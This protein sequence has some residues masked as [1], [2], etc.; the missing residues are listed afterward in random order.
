ML[1]KLGISSIHAVWFAAQV[2]AMC[3]QQGASGLRG[4]T[5]TSVYGGLE[6]ASAQDVVDWADQTAVVRAASS[7]E[8]AYG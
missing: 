5:A 7:G 8:V 3:G 2:V 4:A 1:R 6:P